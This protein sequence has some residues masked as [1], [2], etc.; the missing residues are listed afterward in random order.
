MFDVCNRIA[1]GGMMVYG[2][3]E[4][5]HPLPPN[6]WYDVRGRAAGHGHWIPA[7]G[8]VLRGLLGAMRAK[9]TDPDDIRVISPF[10]HVALEAGR[11]YKSVFPEVGTKEVAKRVGTVHTMQGREADIVILILGSDP[12]RTGSRNWAS[13]TPNLLNVAVS[14]ARDRLYVIGNHD[15]W[16]AHDQFKVLAA[17]LPATKPPASINRPT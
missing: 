8:V 2:A 15:T 11:V 6:A 12:D 9:H 4:H 1:Y 7:E 14:R 13:R 16:R 17:V 3:G 5:P 10:K